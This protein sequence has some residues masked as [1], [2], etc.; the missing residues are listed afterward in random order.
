MAVDTDKVV[1]NPLTVVGGSALS[2]RALDVSPIC[3]SRIIDADSSYSFG[4][5]LVG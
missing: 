3:S 5:L 4:F 1:E 2:A